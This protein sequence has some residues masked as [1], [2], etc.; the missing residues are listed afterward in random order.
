MP[1]PDVNHTISILEDIENKYKNLY[2]HY[3]KYK[4]KNDISK[5]IKHKTSSTIKSADDI[6][7]VIPSAPAG[8]PSPNTFTK[9]IQKVTIGDKEY[10]DNITIN[11]IDI[12]SISGDISISD[13]LTIKIK[14]KKISRDQDI[15]LSYDITATTDVI[16]QPGTPTIRKNITYKQ[17]YT[18]TLQADPKLASKREEKEKQANKKKQEK[19]NK[20]KG[21]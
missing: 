14:G 8:A 15:K 13:N 3:R 19:E 1:T 12:N 20:Q 5:T 10:T 6:F 4:S 11:G 2:Q 7:H 21:E 18:L 17:P 16:I 9:K